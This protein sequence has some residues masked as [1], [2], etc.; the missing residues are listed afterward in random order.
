MVSSWSFSSR[1]AVILAAVIAWP[2]AGPAA[3]GPQL[4]LDPR[5]DDDRL[6]GLPAINELQ[7]VRLDPEILACVRAL[8][9]PSYERREAAM[10]RLLDADASIEQLCAALEEPG[11]SPEQEYRLLT[12]VRQEL[13]TAPRG[14][15]GIKVDQRWW[16]SVIIVEELIEGLPAAGVLK[17]GDRITHLQGKPLRSWDDFRR[18]VQSRKPGDRI[19]MTV[20]RPENG[21]VPPAPGR[22]DDGNYETMAFEIT[23]GSA[24][25]LV[26]TETGLPQRNTDLDRQRQSA[27]NEATRRYSPRAVTVRLD[28]TPDVVVRGEFDFEIES[29]SH[30][31]AVIREQ[32]MIRDGSLLLTPERRAERMRQLEVFK[33]LASDPALSPEIRD[34]HQRLAERYAE[35]IRR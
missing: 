20:E 33:R 14:A 7:A 15:V 30:V 23:L 34:M 2:N 16:P 4:T 5:A 6:F 24:E 8:A 21:A 29:N 25:H 11:L 10:D 3:A 9:D 32:A 18:A 13:L 26:D 1:G 22:E 27:A 35:L 31:Q 17:I 12:I 28:G 19:S